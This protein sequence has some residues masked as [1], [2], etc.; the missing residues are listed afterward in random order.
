MRRVTSTP[1]IRRLHESSLSRNFPMQISEISNLETHHEHEHEHDDEEEEGVHGVDD[2]CEDH[3]ECNPSR[4]VENTPTE[5]TVEEDPDD[6]GFFNIDDEDENCNN[7]NNDSVQFQEGSSDYE[8]AETKEKNRQKELRQQE[9]VALLE[10]KNSEALAAAVRRRSSG[11]NNNTGGKKSSLRRGS[12]YGKKDVG[13]PLDF[14]RKEYNRVL[15]KP[16]IFSKAVGDGGGGGMK[17][18]TSRG[19]FRVSSE[20]VFVRPV[21][22]ENEVEEEEEKQPVVAATTTTA[23]FASDKKEGENSSSSSFVGGATMKRRI[24]FGTIKIREHSQTMGDNPSCTYGTPVQLDWD[25]EEL[26]DIKVEDYENFRPSTRTRQQFH[27]NH[28]QRRNL[29]KLNGFTSAD[30]S[31]T[32]KQVSKIRSQRERT[33]FFVLNYPAL[34]AVEDAFES[35]ARKVKRAVLKAANNKGSGNG[36]GIENDRTDE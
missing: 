24:S 17:K 6:F 29:L 22:L 16:D 35:G 21:Y 1:E 32:K 30:I 7:N 25:Y 14:E 18:S 28:F 36:S 9:Q 2:E 26:A 12:A 33:K 4:A 34:N 15:P 11:N 19:L 13:I 3:K 23:K 8:Q 10:D 31:K 5:H 27:L 20:P